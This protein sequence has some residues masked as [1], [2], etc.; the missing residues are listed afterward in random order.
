MTR[1]LPLALALG[2]TICTVLAPPALAQTSCARAQRA[3]QATSTG[4]DVTCSQAWMN[5]TA[6]CFYCAGELLS[7]DAT[8]ALCNSQ[9]A[10]SVFDPSTSWS[11]PTDVGLS[12]SPPTSCAGAHRACD[13]ANTQ[14]KCTQSWI[15]DSA[16]CLYCSGTGTHFIETFINMCATTGSAWDLTSPISSWDFMPSLGDAESD[17]DKPG[18]DSDIVDQ[19]STDLNTVSVQ[20]DVGIDSTLA[21]SP[22]V[23]TRTSVRQANPSISAISWQY[24]RNCNNARSACQAVST[25]TQCTPMWLNKAALCFYCAEMYSQT[26]RLIDTCSLAGVNYL[27]DPSRYWNFPTAKQEAN[28]YDD[29]NRHSYHNAYS[30]PVYNNNR[31]S[32]G[33]IAGIV[34][35]SVAFTVILAGT[36]FVVVRRRRRAYTSVPKEPENSLV[37]MD[38]EEEGV[39]EESPLLN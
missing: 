23:V 1:P 39:V 25:E 19:L 14:F 7:I 6:L 38:E 16:L 24:P 35:G 18:F 21:F 34:I 29:Y 3:C 28:N 22:S 32:A 5:N 36:A 2:L 26:K 9:G 15:D 8:V 33:A 13:A 31:L 17:I 20:P 30:H 11:F 37:D 4:P 27:Q 12:P 10:R